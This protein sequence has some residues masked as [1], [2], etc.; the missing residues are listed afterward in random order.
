MKKILIV[1][2][3]TVVSFANA[4]KG[5]YLVLGTISFSTQ[6][7]SNQEANDA[8]Y[9]NFGFYPKV[10]YQF[11]DNW[12]VGVETGFS[13]GKNEYLNQENTSKYFSAGAFIR[14]SKSLNQMFVFY[15]D[16]GGGY[17]NKKGT[18]TYFLPTLDKRK[19]TL[20]GVYMNLRPGLFLN[21]KNNF[22]LNFNIGGLSYSNTKG[23][24]N[25]SSFYFNFGESF[26]IGVSKN[27]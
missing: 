26:N 11:K 15:T 21:I 22:G 17:Q 18:Y 3:L 2:A 8:K 6:K 13:Y 10:G 4:Q 5:T 1:L 14:Y 16:L 25:D 19:T 12:T 9:K 23:N 7:V 24:G 27:F 20:D